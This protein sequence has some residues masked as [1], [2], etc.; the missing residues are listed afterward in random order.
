MIVQFGVVNVRDE[1]ATTESVLRD[2]SEAERNKILAMRHDPDL[3]RKITESIAPT[4]YGHREV[5]SGV[6]LMLF[7]GVHK[8]TIEGI[9]SVAGLDGREK[10]RTTHVLGE[11]KLTSHVWRMMMRRV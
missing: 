2:Y 11:A 10:D 5:K 6:L 1:D 3:Y 4:V 9:G 7:G 8:N